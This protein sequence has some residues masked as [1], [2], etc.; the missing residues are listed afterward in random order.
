MC[1]VCRLIGAGILLGLGFGMGLGIAGAAPKAAAPAKSI[2]TQELRIVGADGRL[3]AAIHAGEEGTAMM[4]FY[5]KDDT[6]RLLLSLQANGG[7]GIVLGDQ[8]SRKKASVVALPNGSVGL[9][10]QS[11]R[12]S[13][14]LG[15]T[16]DEDPNLEV[17]DGVGNVLFRAVR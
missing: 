16:R 3:Q 12:G 7:A 17:R 11:D 9:S 5:G 8:E 2:E 6:P 15:S 10:L 14:H 1:A 4:T 13:L